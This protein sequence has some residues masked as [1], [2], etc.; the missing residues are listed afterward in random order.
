M[1]KEIIL[2]LI[3]GAVLSGLICL[4]VFWVV[5]VYLSGPYIEI[6]GKLIH[7]S[8]EDNKALLHLV[9]QGSVLG[10]LGGILYVLQMLTNYIAQG[11][12]PIIQQHDV[13][14]YF[15]Y[16]F[17]TPFKGLIAGIIAATIVG[18]VIFM[19]GGLDHLRSAHL[20]VIG[21]SC[22]AGYSEQFLQRVIDIANKKLRVAG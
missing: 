12:I 11:A 5:T 7:N 17:I 19:V 1:K 2:S 4:L 16:A 18:G 14:T 21:C 20:F 22:I 10:A 8:I 15:L 9:S 13:R 6:T 3:T